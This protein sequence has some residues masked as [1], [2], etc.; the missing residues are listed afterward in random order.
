VNGAAVNLEP[1]ADVA[2]SFRQEQREQGWEIPS[3]DTFPQLDLVD[4]DLVMVPSESQD[5]ELA[6]ILSKALATWTANEVSGIA[7]S[8]PWLC[9]LTV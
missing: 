7:L 5:L 3:A 6:T 4:E 9:D 8:E 2:P 1:V